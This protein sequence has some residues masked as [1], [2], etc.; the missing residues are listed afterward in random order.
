MNSCDF[1]EDETTKALYASY[2]MPI[3]NGQNN[4][5]SHGT[6]TA[7]GV[8]C[9]LQYGLNHK[10]ST[11]DMLSD[12]EKKKH[13]IKEKTMSG[14]N[15]DVLQFPNSAKTNVQVSGKNRSLN[16]M[17]HHPADLNPMKKTSSSKHLSRLDNMIEE[18]NV[19]KEKEK[20]VNEGTS[21]I[22]ELICC[23][24]FL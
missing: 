2:Q 16:A 19:P 17:N 12:R 18:K 20:Q 23:Y 21:F 11:F 15:N 1:S 13:V 9:T 8:S 5:Q 10:M 14:I 6:E 22:S 24:L 3:S 7:I 4:M